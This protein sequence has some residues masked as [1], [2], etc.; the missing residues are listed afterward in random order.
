MVVGAGYIAVEIAGMLAEMG[1]ETHLLIR[2][3]TVLRTFDHTLSEASTEALEKGPVNL[4]KK[5]HVCFM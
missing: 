2:H 1:S 5:T 3:D 4:H